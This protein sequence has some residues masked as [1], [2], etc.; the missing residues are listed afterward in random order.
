MLRNHDAST[1]STQNRGDLGSLT[2]KQ[3]WDRDL[4]IASGVEEGPGNAKG[5]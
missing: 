4:Q 1:N 3:M 5:R 2:R